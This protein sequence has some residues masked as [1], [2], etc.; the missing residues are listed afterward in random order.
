MI[1]WFMVFD[2]HFD[3]CEDSVFFKKNSE[4]VYALRKLPKSARDDDG[5]DQKFSLENQFWKPDGARNS[6]E[7]AEENWRFRRKLI[8]RASL[9]FLPCNFWMML[10]VFF[11]PSRELHECLGKEERSREEIEGKKSCG[12]QNR[13]EGKRRRD[14]KRRGFSGT[15]LFVI[16]RC[17]SRSNLPL[18]ATKVVFTKTLVY[19]VRLIEDWQHLLVLEIFCEN[20]EKRAGK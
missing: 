4:K 11:G 18:W 19:L 7:R 5:I 10:M 12:N 16:F 20:S 9:F 1:Q 3:S 2:K 14:E 17:W 13:Q 6:A 15:K 8:L